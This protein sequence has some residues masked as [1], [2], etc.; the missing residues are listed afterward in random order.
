MPRLM[1]RRRA[2]ARL[3]GSALAFGLAALNGFPAVAAGSDETLEVTTI[4][5][6]SSAGADV[7][8]LELADALGYL[9]PLTLDRRGDVQGGPAALQAAATG[10]TDIAA[11]FNGAV[12]N[13][14]AA[15]AP[16][17]AVI[18]WRGTNNETSPG[19][20]VLDDSPIRQ[21]RDLIGQKVGVN[22][23]GANQEAVTDI[24]LAKNGVSQDEIGQVM[25]VPLPPPNLEQA[26]RNR[27]I[28]AANLGFTLRDVAL[29]HG[30]IRP[31]FRNVDMIGVYNDNSGVLRSDFIRKNPNTTRH[32]VAALAKAI[33]WAQERETDDRR[34][35][36]IDV[37][38][39]Y[40]EARGRGSETGPL[41][42][43][44]SLGIATQGGWI[45]HE[46][47]T[48][49][50]DWLDSRGEIDAKALDVSSIYTNVFNPYSAAGQDRGN[51]VGNR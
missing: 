16:L 40:L 28:G 31:L 42:H 3:G 34:H 5:Y 17:T 50:V 41:S 1:T 32:L 6:L 9:V 2:L 11:A 51:Q 14:I 7:S 36:V 22:T 8:P 20:Y 12:L 49:W 13:V 46:D 24:Y 23:L 37:C 4:R 48:M 18:A 45:K 21:P 25:F 26:L 43:W 29:A 35:E 15:G 47:F 30:G 38:R 39:K 27:E 44:R 19:V 10:Q 33:A